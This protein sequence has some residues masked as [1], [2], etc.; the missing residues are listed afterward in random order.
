M[1]EDHNCFPFLIV[2]PNS[3]CPNWRRE[4][5]QWAPSLRV[6]TYFGSSAAR[7]LAYEHELFPEGSKTLKAHCVVTSYDAAGDDTCRR[8]FKSVPWQGLIVDEGQR[9]KSDKTILYSAL[10]S[11][12]IPFTA[13][14]T[15]TPLQNNARE[16]FNLLQFLD[17]EFDAKALDLEFAEL[18]KEN[19]PQLHNLIRPF[20]LRRT[21]AEVLSFLPPMGQV[22]IPVSMSVLQKKLYKSILA[23]N[24]DLIKAIFNSGSTVVKSERANLSN[25]LM[26]L[27]KCLCHPFVYSQDIEERSTDLEVSHR[28]LVEASPKLQLLSILLPK[29]KERGHRVLIFSQFLDMLDI[30]EDFLNGLGLLFQRLDGTLSSLDKQKRIDHYNA[31]DSELFAFLLSTRAG[32][33]G[34]NLAT[35][36]TVIIMD[37]DFNP[38]QDIQALSRAHRIGQKKK[39]LC[40]QLMTRASAEEKIV[41]IGR[42][43]MALDHVLID[44]MD[45][46][47]E[48]GIDME[49][50]LRHGAAEILGEDD[51]REVKYD[52]QSV[53]KLLDRS[54]LEETKA[55]EENTAESQFSFARVW[56]NDNASLADSIDES[57]DEDSKV[58]DPSIWEKIL[59]E[60]ERAAA[61]E[62]ARR[63]QN[64]GRG[65][66]VRQTI[67]YTSGGV[68]RI[69]DSPNKAQ[70]R[71]KQESDSDTDFQIGEE[72][73][74]ERSQ[75]EDNQG[76]DVEAQEVAL[77]NAELSQLE[78][79]RPSPKPTVLKQQPK[80]TR[81]FRR[82]NVEWPSDP[83]QLPEYAS[84][85]DKENP[86]P[87]IKC[88]ACGN[89]HRQ[90]YCPLK[91][92]GPEYCS[93]CGMAHYGVARTC[94]HIKSETQVKA[95]LA[96]LKQSPEAQDLRSKAAHYLSGVK[97][98][99][100]HAKRIKASRA[101][102]ARAAGAQA[103]R[104]YDISVDLRQD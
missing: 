90:G 55:D 12:K 60:R 40:F 99:L 35:A 81:R 91:L 85:R 11:L 84:Q 70:R 93:L 83:S 49:S 94:P 102:A 54:Q 28:N 78:R 18:T 43:K 14:L 2:V 95:M 68:D 57:S 71:N 29:L 69:G 64:L 20:F 51:S 101:E 36:D 72:S 103:A 15:G 59:Q 42:R 75:D 21:K 62:A 66:R 37:P 89:H 88:L 1:V 32:G 10:Q 3:T 73:E 8:F 52:E 53:D 25:I 41:Q 97:G 34:I 45:A 19:I 79:K 82:S 16:L 13:L 74:A 4:I 31:P 46:D 23:K 47:E 33:I 96:A 22:I 63:Q 65:K 26:Q 77:E 30:V 44:Q 17:E 39:V 104:L 50:I 5:K 24:P 100:A 61:E 48:S 98:T 56:A 92:A 67:D 87:V 86:P 27:R 58:P 9:L 6:V 38:H 7:R 76:D 80:A